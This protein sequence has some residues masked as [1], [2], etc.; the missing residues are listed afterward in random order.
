MKSLEFNL[1][2][3]PSVNTYYRHIGSRTLLSKR[4]REYR[5]QVCVLL[6]DKCIEPLTTELMICIDAYPPDQR[7]RDGDNILKAILDSLQHAGIY[8][9]DCQIKD[10]EVHIR[11]VCKPSGRVSIKLC[12]RG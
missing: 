4:G 12:E 10:F 5:K 2:W 8:A 7:R 6:K 3:P 11:E 1:P 9:D